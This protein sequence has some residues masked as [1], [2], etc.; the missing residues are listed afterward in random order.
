MEEE[1]TEVFRKLILQILERASKPKSW[2]W[3]TE[4]NSWVWVCGD[5]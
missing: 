1:L 2:V 3:V 4:G 5:C